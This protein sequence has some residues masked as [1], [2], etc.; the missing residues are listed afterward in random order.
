MGKKGAVPFLRGLTLV[1]IL[2]TITI[3][4]CGIMGVLSAYGILVDALAVSQTNIK[5][6]CLLKDKMTEIEQMV[7]DE[8]GISQGL[9]IGDFKGSYKDFKWELNVK[10]SSIE[11]LNEVIVIVSHKVKPREFSL[12][13]YVQDKKVNQ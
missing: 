12:V 2:L 3:L 13:T 6:V 7:L 9:S 10:P 4:S 1:E 11:G 8:A 5:A